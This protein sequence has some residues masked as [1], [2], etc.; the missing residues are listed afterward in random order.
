MC[1]PCTT[2]SPASSPASRFR[3]GKSP[4]PFRISRIANI[5]IN[6][7]TVLSRMQTWATSNVGKGSPLARVC[8]VSVVIFLCAFAPVAA[9]YRVT[10][11]KAEKHHAVHEIYRTGV[12]HP[13]RYFAEST[14]DR[15]GRPVIVYYRRYSTAPGYF[16]AF[17]RNHE[18]CHVSGYHNEITASCCA[19]KRMRLSKAG[20]ATVGNYI[21]S[22]DVTPRPPSIIKAKDVSSGAR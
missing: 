5:A 10:K 19:L 1:R 3:M 11:S 22:R 4:V 21:V 2:E 12:S 20:L 8:L 6:D 17:V 16:K 7:G 14:H 9:A 15:S 13:R 18:R